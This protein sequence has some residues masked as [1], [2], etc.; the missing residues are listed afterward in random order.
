MV[1][2]EHACMDPSCR[3]VTAAMMD[4]DVTMID[5]SLALASDRRIEAEASDLTLCPLHSPHSPAF[6]V[7]TT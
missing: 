7:N 1:Q 3:P 5:E 2:E 4:C 6:T